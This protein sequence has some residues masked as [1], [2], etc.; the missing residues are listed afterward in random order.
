MPD[1]ILLLHF[2]ILSSSQLLLPL[3]FL[4]KHLQRTPL[5]VRI[6]SKLHLGGQF[7]KCFLHFF[8]CFL[9]RYAIDGVLFDTCSN[10]I[11]SVETV[12]KFLNS[13]VVPIK[14][15]LGKQMGRWRDYRGGKGDLDS[16]RCN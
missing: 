16:M 13:E 12:I 8:L 10:G 4:K 7:N 3:P 6:I 9:R 11:A 1:C 2:P 15:I 5:P 14:N